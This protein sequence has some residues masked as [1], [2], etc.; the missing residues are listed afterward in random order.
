MYILK[1]TIKLVILTLFLSSACQK[2]F[3]STFAELYQKQRISYSMMLPSMTQPDFGGSPSA[4][5][6]Q[7]SNQPKFVRNSNTTA[8][9]GCS[10]TSILV[11]NAQPPLGSNKEGLV[12]NSPRNTSTH[13]ASTRVL[14]RGFPISSLVNS[15]RCA[16]SKQGAVA[17]I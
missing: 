4:A 16:A 8:N 2:K 10:L 17:V 3:L 15:S 1:Y 6:L 9:N 14:G 11:D 13:P 12:F 5:N 7:C